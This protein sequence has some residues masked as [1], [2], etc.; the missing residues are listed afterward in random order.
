MN[1][2]S[3]ILLNPI[4]RGKKKKSNKRSEWTET[5]EITEI[6]IKPSP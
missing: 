1:M 4:N 5:D 3:E 6:H 2:K